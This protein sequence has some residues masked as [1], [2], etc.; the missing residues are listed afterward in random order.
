MVIIQLQ[1]SYVSV[2]D[3]GSLSVF[4]LLSLG[5]ELNGRAVLHKG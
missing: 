3:F 1:V 4:S 5:A 2:I